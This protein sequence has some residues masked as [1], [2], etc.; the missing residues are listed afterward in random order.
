VRRLA[1]A[2]VGALCLLAP[3]LV[4]RPPDLQEDVHGARYLPPLSRAHAL[5]VEP[6]RVLV[7][8]ALE[9]TASGWR[10]FRAGAPGEIAS[11]TLLAPPAPRFY[12]FGT[13]GL[14]RDLA[15]RLAFGARHSVGIAALAVVLA[16]AIGIGVGST[17]G[18]SGATWDSLSM[19][20]VDVVLS[21]PRL[22]VYLL[23]AALFRPSTA[24][25]VLVLGATTWTGLARLVRAET[26][27]WRGSELALAAR[28]AGA[29][30]VRLLL[31]HVL[32]Q[33]APLVAVSA[34]LR[35]ADTLLLEAALGFLG[36]GAPPPAVSLGSIIA[37]GTDALAGAWWVAF[38]P[39]ATIVAL[40]LT[41]R[42]TAT[43][44]FRIPEGPSAA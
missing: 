15:S 12:L 1:L 32:P 31:R 19:R 36:L 41:V 22:L 27:A 2:A 4:A 23:C 16:L 35:F 28:A 30:R 11:A 21:V 40:V 14:G 44:L 3:S 10:F 39:G 7:V 43:S 17:A 38:W 6:H 34:A 24:L 5:E 29:T 25:L 8:T 18:L 26:L 13:D 9:R 42:S 33:M 20:S 37:S